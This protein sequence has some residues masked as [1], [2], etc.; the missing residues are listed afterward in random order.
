MTST[1][2]QAIISCL[3]KVIFHDI[4]TPDAMNFAPYGVTVLYYSENLHLNCI[5]WDVAFFPQSR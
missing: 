3:C 5:V 4:Y 1:L 2:A